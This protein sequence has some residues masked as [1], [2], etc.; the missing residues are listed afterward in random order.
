MGSCLFSSSEDHQI[1]ISDFYLS[2][3]WEKKSLN[4]KV[5]PMPALQLSGFSN[6][7]SNNSGDI[8]H[9]LGNY[10]RYS[11]IMYNTPVSSQFLDYIKDQINFLQNLSTSTKNLFKIRLDTSID[12][13]WF[14]KERLID[15]GFQNL[16]SNN[17]DNI[18]TSLKNSRLCIITCNSTSLIE[19][20]F[21]DV[22]TIIFWNSKHWQLRKD[23]KKIYHDLHQCGVLH[24]TSKSAA[25]MVN[26]IQHNPRLWWDNVD[27]QKSGNNF[28]NDLRIQKVK[29]CK[30]GKPFCRVFNIK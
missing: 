13:N 1:D 20:L 8:L 9:V 16:I 7:A 4:N 27:I 2:W 24:Y 12:Y 30:N 22:P 6:V 29:G 18:K 5:V 19:T 14:I 3:G 10:P 26:K 21:S 11:Y 25:K 17:K 28:V 23:A 15:N